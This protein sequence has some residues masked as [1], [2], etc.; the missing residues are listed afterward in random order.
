MIIITVD[1]R[2]QDLVKMKTQTMVFILDIADRSPRTL[3]DF[4]WVGSTIHDDR[5]PWC[6][7]SLRGTSCGDFMVT[8]VGNVTNP[9]FNPAV[10]TDTAVKRSFLA[11]IGTVGFVTATSHHFE[12]LRG[13]DGRSCRPSLLESRASSLL[14]CFNTHSIDT[15]IC[16]C[17]SRPDP[18]AMPDR[19]ERLGSTV[20]PVSC[21]LLW[22]RAGL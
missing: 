11:R 5:N 7:K 14:H 2:V 21:P 12:C 18:T 20:L 1:T 8:L 15:G 3:T 19:R 4:D 16:R 9:R 6:H 22:I 10:E 13:I 17:S